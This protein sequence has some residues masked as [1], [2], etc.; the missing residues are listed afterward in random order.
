MRVIA[1]T[2][3]AVFFLTGFASAAQGD[4]TIL[5]SIDGLR[6]DYLNR[7]ITPALNDLARD[8]VRSAMQPSFPSV[9]FPKHYTLITG[10]YP[11][12]HGI[13]NNSFEDKTLGRVWNPRDPFDPVWSNLRE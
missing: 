1:I 10:L 13:V 2:V 5:I 12:H 4:I 6:A 9:T 8:G 3:I 11:D 7:G